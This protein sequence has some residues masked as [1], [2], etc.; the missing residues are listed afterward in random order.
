[1]QTTASPPPRRLTLAPGRFR[2]GPA[3]GSVGIFPFNGAIFSVQTTQSFVYPHP[4]TNGIGGPVAVPG[5][6]GSRMLSKG[7]AGGGTVNQG[8]PGLTTVSFY[9][10]A[11]GFGTPGNNFGGGPATPGSGIGING[12]ARFVATSNQFGGVVVGRTLGTRRVFYNVAGLTPAEL[13][14]YATA[15]CQI[16]LSSVMASTGMAPTGDVTGGPFGS[17]VMSGSGM[18]ATG[19]FTATLGFNATIIGIGS[20]VTVAGVNVPFTGPPV[21]RVG[22]PLTTGRLSLTVTS[23]GPGA[24]TEMFKRTG[25]DNRTPSGS[26]VVSLVT[27]SLSSRSFG[28][29]STSR[30]G[31]L[32]ILLPEPTGLLAAGGVL[33]AL[34]I[35]HRLARR[36][37]G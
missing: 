4:G 27:G 11:S 18:T 37:S 17:T 19:V 21:T 14:C 29:P 36:R 20:P 31:Y 34:A 15:M 1:M 13:P 22:F 7:L 12:V 5:G 3:A 23:V 6:G 9:K 16:G 25:G 26:G 33:L 2:F 24:A 35:G 8:R 10:G 30:R 28:G 32:T